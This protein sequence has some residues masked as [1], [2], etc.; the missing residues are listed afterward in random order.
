MAK[1]RGLGRGLGALIPGHTKD[2]TPI[3]E[4]KNTPDASQKSTRKKS[5]STRASVQQAKTAEKE[6]KTAATRKKAE[7]KVTEP[8]KSKEKTQSVNEG[9]GITGCF[10]G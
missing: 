10:V 7:R 3:T 9:L 2:I 1:K 5:N 8:K 4:T 6:T